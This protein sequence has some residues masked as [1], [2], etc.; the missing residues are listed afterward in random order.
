[1]SIAINNKVSSS[2]KVSIFYLILLSVVVGAGWFTTRYLGDKARQE[3]LQFNESTILTHSSHFT[4]ELDHIEREVRVLSWSPLIASALISLKDDVIANANSTLDR[5][6]SGLDSSVSYLM[7]SNGMTIASSNRNDKDSFV[8]KSYQF[9]PYFIQAMKDAPGRYFALGVTSLKRGFYA[10][11]PV[12]DSKGQIIGVVVIKK[13]IDEKEADL[14]RY[15]YFFLVD[16]NGII[17][18]SSRKEM[19]FKSLWPISPETRLALLESGQF[20]EREFDAVLPRKIVDGMEIR[21]D[22]KNYLTSRKVINPE[23]WS[24]VIMTSTERISEYELVGVIISMWICT[25]IVVPM[26]INYRASRS[27]EMLRASETRYRELFDNTSSGV[28]IYEAKDGGKDFILKDFNKAGE[29]IDGVRKEDSI[30]KSIHEVRPG[31][32]EFGLMDVFER[33]WRTGIPEHHPASFY[34]DQKLALWSE[35]FVYKLPTGEVVA[36]YDNITD[37]IRAEE[38]LRE[39]E[40]KYRRIVETANEGICTTDADNLVTYVNQ[41]MADMLGYLPEV[42]TGKPLVHLLFPEDLADH[43]GKWSHRVQGLSETYERRFRRSDGGECWT[44]ASVTVI[45]TAD[46]RFMG[47]FGMLTDITERKQAEAMLASVNRQNELLL[48]SVGDGILG[49]DLEGRTTFANP[50]AV[51]LVGY[52]LE[53]MIGRPQHDLIHHSRT[54][55]SPYLREECPIYAAFKDG[56][57]HHVDTE[58]FWRKDGTSFPVAY[59]STPIR[60]ENSKLQ[61]AVVV[62]SDITERKLAEAEKIQMEQRLQKLEKAESLGRMAGSIA[63]HFNNKLGAVIGNL[64]LALYYLP[65]E[66]DIRVRIVESMKASLQ[67]AEVSRMM[68]A[69]LGQTTG[70]KEPIDLVETIRETLPLLDASTSQHV[71]LKTDFPPRRPIILGDGVH[72]K[73]ILANL[74]SN[75]AEAIDQ[76]EGDITVAIQVSAK[77]ESQGLRFFPLEW[78]PK[79]EQYVCLSVSDTGC[80]MD[81]ATQEKVFDPFFSTKFIG[82]GLGLPVLLGLVRAHDGAITVMSSPGRGAVFRVFFPLH[83]PWR[84]CRHRRKNRLPPDRW[85]KEDWFSW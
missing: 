83:I 8:G 41:K 55:G 37:R 47:A 85:S 23:G 52:D 82:R 76:N 3:I 84:Q 14:S 19:T 21:F 38:A 12:K 60:D 39:S 71:H 74:V 16:P 62:F 46:G 6:N 27:A 22:G 50:K 33:V 1:M 4:G 70:R 18:L 26:I 28:A 78:E 73:Q 43:Q 72:I 2:Y 29:R 75:A 53:E 36:V 42:I 59:T 30:G 5:Y 32:K 61:G 7:D 9:R 80:G 24:T 54:D 13:D 48:N 49:L 45:R 15:P 63:H 20:G 79:E 40:E 11:Y 17:F 69:Y 64:E 65:E 25:L 81:V 66:S 35:N 34:H 44:I 51:R 77:A 68:L 10:S 58:V 67:A 57:V 56:Q 31:I